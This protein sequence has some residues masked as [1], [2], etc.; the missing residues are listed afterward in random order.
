VRLSQ[1]FWLLKFCLH[2]ILL[3]LQHHASC[4]CN[5]HVKS[6]TRSRNNERFLLIDQ[7]PLYTTRRF[8]LWSTVAQI[9][10]DLCSL[11]LPHTIYRSVCWDL[12]TAAYSGA[13]YQSFC[14]IFACVLFN[15][16]MSMF[17]LFHLRVCSLLAKCVRSCI[18]LCLYVK[19]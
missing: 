16:H 17:L 15:R 4:K 12:N 19:R 11:S 1:S 7:M 14:V 3:I 2:Q 18:S 13:N 10:L 6:Y 9:I 5:K 8:T